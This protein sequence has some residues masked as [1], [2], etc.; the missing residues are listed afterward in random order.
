MTSDLRPAGISNVRFL[1]GAHS[2]GPQW[3]GF[4]WSPPRQI[5]ARRCSNFRIACTQNEVPA[6]TKAANRPLRLRSDCPSMSFRAKKW[7]RVTFAPA[8]AIISRASDTGRT[9]CQRLNEFPPLMLCRFAAAV[10]ESGCPD[11]LAVPDTGD[12][13]AG[14]EVNADVFI[15]FSNVQKCWRR[16]GFV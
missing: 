15:G 1:P 10:N 14:N 7:C 13:I 16:P 4:P 6:H 5:P 11:G 9:S 2:D 3:P 12:S 8:A